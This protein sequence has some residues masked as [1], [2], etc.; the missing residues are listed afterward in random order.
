MYTVM[1]YFVLLW[2]LSLATFNEGFLICIISKTIQYQKIY[3]NIIRII[4]CQPFV[5]I[6]YIKM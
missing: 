6:E 2:G 3:L 5:K 4:I 1:P